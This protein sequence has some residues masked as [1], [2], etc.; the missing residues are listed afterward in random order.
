MGKKLLKS[1]MSLSGIYGSKREARTWEEVVVLDLTETM[2]MLK[3]C[4]N[5][6]HSFR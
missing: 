6:M 3:K 5:L 4:G 1:Q 2:K